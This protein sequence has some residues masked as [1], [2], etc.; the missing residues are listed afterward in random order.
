MGT[1][2]AI[3][4]AVLFVALASASRASAF[5]EFGDNC[6]GKVPLPL[7]GT[8]FQSETTKKVPLASPLAGVITRWRVNA[9][10]PPGSMEETL[11]LLRG[12]P[13]SFQVAGES[14]AEA[15]VDGP[16]MFDT[17]LA[18]QV[19]D[20]LG[21]YGKL[22]FIGCEGESS[23]VIAAKSG[24]MTTGTPFSPDI[25]TGSLRIPLAAIVEPDADGDGYGDE[26][27]DGCPADAS[28]H[29]ACPLPRPAPALKLDAFPIVL[30][31]SILL[32]V[33]SS[34]S[35]PVEVFGQVG[36]RRRHRGGA[37]ASK[38]RKPKAPGA[39]TIVGL[40]GGTEDVEAGEIARFNVKLPGAVKRELR[41]TPRGKSLKG[42][43]TARA[44]D[45]SGKV[46]DRTISIRLPGQKPR[47]G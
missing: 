5:A 3:S 12:G 37:L 19:G 35:R 20:R 11:K 45:S 43:I 22:G 14:G 34:E 6:V 7:A 41:Q 8:V 36:L 16:N 4:A 39:G 30:K 38:T 27:Q 46:V 25:T 24:N 47:H 28:T 1:R 17:R 26:T 10:I 15:V 9:E 32:L 23:D 33:G 31:R 29:A 18:V 42:T 21:L 44:T 2:I 13:T 40:D